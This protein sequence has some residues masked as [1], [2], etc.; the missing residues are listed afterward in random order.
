M[1]DWESLFKWGLKMAGI[2]PTSF[3]SQALGFL[4]LVALLITVLVVVLTGVAKLKSVFLESFIPK[5]Y[6]SSERSKSLARRQFAEYLRSEVARLNRSENWRDDDF[7]ELEAEVEYVSRRPGYI[8]M[9][10]GKRIFKARSLSKALER[11]SERLILVEGDPGAGKS[12]SLRH[13]V[14]HLASK[15]ARSRRSD[16]VLPIYVNLKELKRAPGIAVDHYLIKDMVLKSLTRI[17]DRFIDEFIESEFD[18]GTRGG[19]WIFLF[20]SFDEIPEILSSTD[21]DDII[22]KYS[23]AIADFL[24]GVNNCRG[25][26]ASRAYRGPS[27]QEW[28]IF[29]VTA[30]TWRRQKDLI[31]KSMVNNVVKGNVVEAGILNSSD[32]VRIMA[33]NPM[34][35][36]LLCEHV[37]LNGNFP[38]TSFEVYSRY[39]EYRFHRDAQRVLKRFGLEVDQLKR[40]ATLAAYCMTADAGL[41]L[42]PRVADVINSAVSLG[43]N[44]DLSAYRQALQAIAYMRLAR[45]DEADEEAISFTFAHRRFQEYLATQVVLDDPNLVPLDQLITDGRWRETAV[46]MIQTNAGQREREIYQAAFKVLETNIAVAVQKASTN[47]VPPIK[48]FHWAEKEIHILG[49]IQAGRSA[50]IIDLPDSLTKLIAER[51]RAA[52]S[53]LN[54]LDS[55]LALEVAGAGSLDTLKEL[56][57]NALLKQSRWLNDIVYRQAARL[58]QPESSVYSAIRKYIVRLVLEGKINAEYHSTRAYMGRLPDSKSLIEA[59]R[60]GQALS[61][62]DRWGFIPLVIISALISTSNWTFTCLSVLIN[63]FAQLTQA[64]TFTAKVFTKQMRVLSIMF[65]IAALINKSNNNVLYASITSVMITIIAVYGEVITLSGV[66]LIQNN[67]AAKV[68]YIPIIPFISAYVWTKKLYQNPPPIK[69]IIAF[70]FAGVMVPLFGFLITQYYNALKY[71]ANMVVLLGGIVTVAMFIILVNGA[72]REY[73]LYR[74]WANSPDRYSPNFFCKSMLNAQVALVHTIMLSRLEKVEVKGDLSLWSAEITE[75]ISSFRNRDRKLHLLRR[76]MLYRKS[77]HDPRRVNKKID[78]LGIIKRIQIQLNLLS[79][80]V[81]ERD[82]IDRRRDLLFMTLERFS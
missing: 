38:E 33:R 63:A 45:I 2:E 53:T 55:K 32:D 8:E 69:A 79:T 52:S 73:K 60:L 18:T 48:S 59:L 1:S 26:V 5:T 22:K 11:S 12:V 66:S 46:V 58:V 4:I 6:S 23:E 43:F 54:L 9:I 62:I 37:R 28:T 50:S 81:L 51:L 27:A 34:L 72:Y 80:N 61:R 56:M 31:Y 57:N 20:D 14:H 24:G 68:R 42:T 7:A 67:K 10:R 16:T 78:N 77:D 47:P 3:A 29:R 21:S 71:V 40:Y 19:R 13:V 64:D 76:S 15:A 44:V 35:L 39:L 36:G 17:N 70:I 74:K 82:Y 75:L 65:A 49:I 30:L 41:G 25:I